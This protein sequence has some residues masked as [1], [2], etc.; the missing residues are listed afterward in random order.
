MK[1]GILF[2]GLMMSIGALAQTKPVASAKP[3]VTKSTTNSKVANKMVTMKNTK[4]I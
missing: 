1:K 3:A 4:D 2:I